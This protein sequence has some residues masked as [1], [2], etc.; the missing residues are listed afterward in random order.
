MED[1]PALCTLLLADLNRKHGTQVPE[2]SKEA[3]ELL[4]HYRWPGNVRELRNAVERAVI[5]AGDGS[6]LARHLPPSLAPAAQA[7]AAAGDDPSLFLTLPPGTTIE[8]AER[9][10]VLRTVQF[11][12]NNKT[13]AAEILGISLKTLFNKLKIYDLAEP[14]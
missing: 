11:T 2:V 9:A 5:L 14:D 10:L 4:R 1:I 13:R 7:H 3:L 12:N 8:D 6:I